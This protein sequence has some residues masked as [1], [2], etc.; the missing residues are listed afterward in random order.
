MNRMSDLM[1][2]D[3]VENVIG[4]STKPLEEKERPI[5]EGERINLRTRDYPYAHI[6]G[7]LSVESGGLEHGEKG[8][9]DAHVTLPPHVKLANSNPSTAFLFLAV[10]EP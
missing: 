10:P 4:N 8:S 7:L 3:R 1:S 5:A 2:H 9:R 6:S